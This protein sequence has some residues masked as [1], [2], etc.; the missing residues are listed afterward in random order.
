VMGVNRAD[1]QRSPALSA[2]ATSRFLA[3]LELIRA[4]E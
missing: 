2:E 1:E 3:G 4:G